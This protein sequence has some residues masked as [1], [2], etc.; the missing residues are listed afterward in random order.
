MGEGIVRLWGI[1]TCELMG[2]KSPKCHLANGLNI[3]SHINTCT[4]KI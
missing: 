2:I 4:I 1:H 3:T